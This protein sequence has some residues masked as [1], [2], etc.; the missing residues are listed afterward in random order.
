M[1]LQGRAPPYGGER[2]PRVKKGRHAAH[3][4]QGWNLPD[5]AAQIPL[6]H[7]LG[8]NRTPVA[9]VRPATSSLK[10]PN[11]KRKALQ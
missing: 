2:P 8:F 4:A 7:G 1:Q 6:A 5:C 3:L 9:L 11:L 10:Y